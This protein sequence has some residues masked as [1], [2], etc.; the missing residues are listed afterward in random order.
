MDR[1]RKKMNDYYLLECGY[2]LS[3]I[4]YYN[5]DFGYYRY[6]KEIVYM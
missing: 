2:Y 3:K 6:F 4:D 1:I 5:L